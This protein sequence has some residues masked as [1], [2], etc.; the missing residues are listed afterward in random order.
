MASLRTNIMAAPTYPRL[1]PDGLF[2][3]AGA[4]GDLNTAVNFIARGQVGAS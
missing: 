3:L 2:L 4:R 1:L